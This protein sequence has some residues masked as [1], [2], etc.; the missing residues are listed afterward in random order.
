M[1]KRFY[2]DS[3]AYLCILL[4]ESGHQ[5]VEKELS[6]SQ[7]LSSVLLILEAGR[8]LI[9]LSRAGSLPASKLQDCLQRL[10]T[11]IEL[12]QLRDLTLDLCRGRVVPLVS[13]PRSLD[14]AHL[15]TALWFHQR[16]SLTRFVTLDGQQSEAARE[17]GLPV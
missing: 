11:D 7:L 9:R 8:N 13:T 10:E 2:V 1:A 14:L 6:G 12:F 15:R 4:G 3:S 17:M 16:E 5:D